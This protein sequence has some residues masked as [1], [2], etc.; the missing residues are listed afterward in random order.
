MFPYKYYTFERL[1]KNVGIIS[2]AGQDE[3][4]VQWNQEQFEENIEK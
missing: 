3:L 2:E 4:K 1:N